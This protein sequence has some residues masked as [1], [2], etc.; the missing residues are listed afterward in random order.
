[1]VNP[2]QQLCSSAHA[3]LVAATCPWCGDAIIAGRPLAEAE[4]PALDHQQEAI[5]RY[6]CERGGQFSLGQ[7]HSELAARQPAIAI[8]PASLTA[9][10]AQLVASGLLYETPSAAE[11]IYTVFR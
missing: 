4:S 7:L 1:M 11:A 6:L 3:Q 8:T 10:L 5:I 2:Y 9:T